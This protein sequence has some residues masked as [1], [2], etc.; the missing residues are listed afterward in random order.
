MM[1]KF[2][3]KIRGLIIL[4]CIIFANSSIAAMYK[5]VD[6]KGNTH[7]TQKPPSTNVEVEIIKPPRAVDT[8]GAN[9]SLDEQK[10]KAGALRDDRLSKA[11]EKRKAEEKAAIIDKHCKQ[12]QAS[13]ASYLRP[14]V[15]N[16]NEDGSLRVL[17][18]E[19]RQEGISK[20]QKQIDEYCG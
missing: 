16:E 4:C 14:R 13:K 15:T 6:E 20:A 18:E 3:Y 19:E 5:W 8:E 1:S 11:D 10:K 2:N 9:K 12:A 7:Y 17:T